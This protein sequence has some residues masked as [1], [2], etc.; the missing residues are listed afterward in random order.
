[1]KK[2]FIYGAMATGLLLTAC[3][4]DEPLVPEGNGVSEIDQTLYVNMAIRGDSGTRGSSDNGSPADDNT[5]FSAG[6]NESAVESAYFV[7]YDA[8]GTQVGDVVN[9]TLSGKTDETSSP[10]GSV[11]K[12]YTSVVPVSIRKGEAKPTQVICYINPLSPASLQNPLSQVQTITRQRVSY[13]VTDES[14]EGGK[15]TYFP[16]SNSVH[17]HSELAD[18][19]LMMAVPIANEQ[20]YESEQAAKDALNN[21]PNNALVNVYVE[22]Y[23]AKINFILDKTQIADFETTSEIYSATEAAREEAAVTLSFKPGKW[24]LNGECKD[25]YIVKSLRQYATGGQM[26]GENFKYEDFDKL[27]NAVDAG[28]ENGSATNTDSQLLG[29]KQWNWN[30][31]ALHRCYWACSPAYFT[32]TYPEVADDY[33]DISITHPQK[34]YTFAE[35]ET[36]GQ[37][38]PTDANG[39]VYYA[40]ETTVGI[41]ALKGSNNPAA[42]IASIVLTGNYEIKVNGTTVNSSNAPG[43][44]GTFYTYLTNKNGKPAIYFPADNDGKS[45]V[46]GAESLM[47]RLI[48]QTTVLYKKDPTYASSDKYIRLDYNND[49]DYQTILD[50]V[51]IIR[52]EKTEVVGK[53]KVPARY[54]SLQFKDDYTTADKSTGIYIANGHG[55]REIVADDA[56][57]DPEQHKITISE[58]NKILM[59]QVGFACKYTTGAAYFSIPV[60]HLGWYRTGNE[61]KTPEEGTKEKINWNIVRVGDF[62]IVRNHSYKIN[63]T[64]ITGLGTGI[65]GKDD[66]IIPPTDTQ[67]YFVAYRVNILK[68]AV[69]PQQD[70]EL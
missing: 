7:F 60:K 6:N 34:Y 23:A 21:N 18:K 43:F 40:K 39:A 4:S 5:D 25:T 17:Y 31:P 26:L 35:V 54:V 69:V 30:A 57:I 53:L 29:G 36:D 64:G 44:D 52:P 49:N 9:V 19:P 47:H 22:R 59:Q 3:S 63:V 50:A 62:G 61:Q 38:C 58:A 46:T 24:V 55:Y 51:K 12:Y 48:A 16:M 10:S 13:T 14:A 65:G 15:K 68:W 2:T 27:I 42:A 28:Y 33:K 1:M 11:E 56:T 67:D 66:P 37:D 20:L 32:D 41:P 8:N 70:V 45:I